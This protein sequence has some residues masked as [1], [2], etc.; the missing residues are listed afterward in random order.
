MPKLV[1]RFMT[2]GLAETF[3]SAGW[4]V[5]QWGDNQN[6][7][8]VVQYHRP[9][10]I[11]V[12][13]PSTHLF[14]AIHYNRHIIVG[15]LTKCS[16]LPFVKK[17]VG[18]VGTI[19]TAQTPSLRCDIGCVTESDEACELLY[20][21]SQP[22][23][24]YK[25]RIF[26]TKPYHG[27]ERLGGPGVETYRSLALSA[28]VILS[29]GEPNEAVMDAASLGACVLSTHPSIFPLISKHKLEEDINEYLMD[30]NKRWKVGKELQ[31]D[32]KENE[33]YAK[34]VAD[35]FESVGQYSQA[36]PFR[37]LQHRIIKGLS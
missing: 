15:S 18:T 21:L 27:A 24:P 16:E 23:K 5:E 25:L 4:S 12:D 14:D 37:E 3:Y 17:W 30:S 33:T 31:K 11:W 32:V 22:G 7:Y 35:W 10:M 2:P 29:I 8:E 19:L 9:D 36:R 13:G 28:K 26:S 1:T 20:P 34:Y 6:P